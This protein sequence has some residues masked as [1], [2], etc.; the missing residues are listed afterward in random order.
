MY[1]DILS[2]DPGET[3]G[4]AILKAG[5]SQTIKYDKETTDMLIKTGELNLW[6]DLENLIEESL[7]DIIVYEEFK[8]YPWR[9][10]QKHWSTFPTAQVVGVIKY[11]ANKFDLPVLGQ[12]ADAKD[13]Y[14]DKKLKWCNLYKGRSP[15]ERDAIR[16]GLYAID[17]ND[18]LWE[19]R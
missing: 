9:A 13:H 5:E 7:C 19:V 12:G 4:Y 16:H 8:L 15:H 1:R 2:I 10:K 3:T 18:K 17:F 11:L 14:D 6:Y